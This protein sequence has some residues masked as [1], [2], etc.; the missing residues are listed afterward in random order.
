VAVSGGTITP[1]EKGVVI[2]RAR[3]DMEHCATAC[4]YD[5]FESVGTSL[6]PREL[7]EKLLRDEVFYRQSGG[8]VTYS[9]GEAAMQAEFF[10]ETTELLAPHGIHV[11]LDTCGYVPWEKLGPLVSMVDLVLYDIKGMDSAVHR[12]YTGV[13][14]GLILENARKV[15]AAGKEMVVRLILVPGVNDS[16]EEMRGRLSFV[17]DLGVVSQV[18]I[19]KYH[20]LAGGKYLRLGLDEPMQDTPESTD[21]TAEAFAEMAEA[22]GFQVTIGG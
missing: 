16:E 11:T 6:S 14:N 9:G 1:G 20:R 3:T 15:A 18:D 2:D 4:Y 12:K 13:D 22:M 17:K 21:D 19:L 8:G 7:A 10:M 5:C